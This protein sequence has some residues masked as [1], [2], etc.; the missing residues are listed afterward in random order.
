MLL[1]RLELETI[2]S[3]FLSQKILNL[4]FANNSFSGLTLQG[5]QACINLA[6]TILTQ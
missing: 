1:N 2:E 4:N 3:G 5:L 6:Q